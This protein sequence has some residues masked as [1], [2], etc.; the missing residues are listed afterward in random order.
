MKEGFHFIRRQGTM[1]ALIV[2]A[3]IDDA[4]GVSA[5][6]LSAGFRS[7]CFSRRPESLH[8]FSG[9]FGPGIYSAAR[10]LVAWLG[11]HKH[12]GLL[13]LLMLLGLG[14]LI[15]G[16]ALS[17]SFVLSCVLIFLYGAMLLA[18]FTS[19]SS[20]V[21]LIA[22]DNMRGRVISVYN[23]AFRG[24]MPVGSLVVGALVKQFTAPVVITA[25]GALLTLLAL[26]FLLVHRKVAT[27]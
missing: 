3:F 5:D 22:P 27:L 20:L 15:G 14:V 18:V 1:E 10:L 4:A 26:Y 12:M 19:I 24:G 16:F 23:V 2:L 8:H 13:V 21:Q 11:K 7:R 25:N 6:R 9:L 17:H